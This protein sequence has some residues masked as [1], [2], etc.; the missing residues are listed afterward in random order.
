MFS[1]GLFQVTWRESAQRTSRKWS[2]Y[3]R[4]LSTMSYF[5]V[6]S[7]FTSF[8]QIFPCCLFLLVDPC[9]VVASI[10]PFCAVPLRS[11][12]W[13]SIRFHVGFYPFCPNFF[14]LKQKKKAKNQLVQNIYMVLILRDGPLFLDGE[15]EGGR[16]G[17]RLE[18]CKINCLHVKVSQRPPPPGP[19]QKN[20]T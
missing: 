3:L 17:G 1:T 13:I 20:T 4:V 5:H 15:G 10:V 11:V 12:P 7:I 8:C 9:I 16:G 2:V 18:N 6:F 14:L 19:Q